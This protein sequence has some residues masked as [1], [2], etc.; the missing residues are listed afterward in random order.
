M[1]TTSQ[2]YNQNCSA[3]RSQKVLINQY[4]Y[5]I[6]FDWMAISLLH[7][8]IYVPIDRRRDEY[9]R[10]SNS[11]HHYF[12]R[13]ILDRHHSY[14]SLGILHG[15]DLLQSRGK[16]H[17]LLESGHLVPRKTRKCPVPRIVAM[18]V[19]TTMTTPSWGSF[20]RQIPFDPN[21]VGR[22]P[23]TT[24]G[25]RGEQERCR[26]RLWCRSSLLFNRCF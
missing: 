20:L 17:V 22:R 19:T 16:I 9:H 11:N 18:Q 13:C 25:R 4:F 14:H 26:S 2:K 21:G 3:A 23:K 7:H 15:T 10:N 6:S 8:G 12:L 5:R 24:K 1:R